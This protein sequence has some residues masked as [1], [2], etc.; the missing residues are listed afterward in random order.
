MQRDQGV[1]AHQKRVQ[2]EVGKPSKT[3]KKEREK[4]EGRP[5]TT[6][7]NFLSEKGRG[8]SNDF[9]SGTNQW[10]A[11]EYVSRTR[12]WGKRGQR[13]KVTRGGP[14]TDRGA[15]PHRNGSLQATFGPL[16]GVGN[17]WRDTIHTRLS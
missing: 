1:P 13:A 8:P 4:K 6:N 2:T 3:R 5:L 12:E 14:L 17:S 16:G 10:R 15:H 9:A 11:G 7:K